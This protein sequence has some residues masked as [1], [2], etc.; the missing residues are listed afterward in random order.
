[1]IERAIRREQGH[2]NDRLTISRDTAVGGGVRKFRKLLTSL[3]NVTRSIHALFGAVDN[4][5]LL[6]GGFRKDTYCLSSLL[7]HE[8][9]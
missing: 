8:H 7:Q 5:R 4:K 3:G 2:P 6:R 9:V 1:M